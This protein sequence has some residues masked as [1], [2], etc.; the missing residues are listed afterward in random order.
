MKEEGW[1]K[2]EITKKCFII[3]LPDGF[4]LEDLFSQWADVLDDCLN[5]LYEDDL[6]KAR[7]KPH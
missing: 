4:A 5:D 2:F 7:Q 1:Q 6:C 3:L